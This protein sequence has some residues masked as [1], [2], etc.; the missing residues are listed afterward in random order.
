MMNQ[1][2]SIC[3]ILQHEQP[4]TGKLVEISRQTAIRPKCNSKTGNHR[5]PENRSS[6]VRFSLL[7]D[8]VRTPCRRLRRS[9]LPLALQV[10][11]I[12]S[13][14]LFANLYGQEKGP[15]NVIFTV[16]SRI[17]L[18]TWRG[19]PL[20]AGDAQT[21]PAPKWGITWRHE[22]GTELRQA[23]NTGSAKDGRLSARLW[24]SVLQPDGRFVG[25]GGISTHCTVTAYVRGLPGTSFSIQRKH[26]VSAL[27]EANPIDSGPITVSVARDQANAGRGTAQARIRVNEPTKVEKGVSTGLILFLDPDHPTEPYSL[28]YQDEIGPNIFY[29]VDHWDY[30]GGLL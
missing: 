5:V 7:R 14:G 9:G 10:L 30:Q 11:A 24:V 13:F 16:Y 25:W 20:V 18:E 28:A 8:G 21:G 26:D 15:A 23:L 17:H 4:F 6:R 19:T 2:E 12:L 29:L 22:P 1:P 27:A 3:R